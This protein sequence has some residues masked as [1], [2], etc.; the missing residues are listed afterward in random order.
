M[1]LDNGGTLLL[2]TSWASWVPHDLIYVNLYGSDGGATL[3]LGGA[4]ATYTKLEVWTEINGFPAEIQPDIPAS[5]GHTEAVLDFLAKVTSDTPDAYRGQE[6]L[7]RSVVV[8]A[9]YA[10]AKL[11]HEVDISTT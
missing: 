9:C 5:G 8:D 10:S 3:E 1:R 2:E 6:G 11:Q 7:A 4:P